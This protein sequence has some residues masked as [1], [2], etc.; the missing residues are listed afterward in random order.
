MAAKED[1][2]IDDSLKVDAV[3]R[4]LEKDYG[5]GIVLSGQDFLENKVQLIPFSP[6]F[7]IILGGGLEEGSF[8]GLTGQPKIGKTTAALDFAATCQLAQYGCR[9][10]FYGKVEGRLSRTHLDG[11]RR[12]NKE[13]GKFNIITS[14]PDK[15]LT[16]QDHL[17]AYKDILTNV[18]GAVLIID[19]ISSLCDERELA[20]GVGTETRGGTAKLFNQFLRLVNQVVPVNRCIVIGI[21]HLISNTSGM[22]APWVERASQGWK[23]MC[24]YQL[25]AVMKKPWV[26]GKD[27]VGFTTTWECKTSKNGPPGLKIDSWFR[28]GEGID[29]LTELIEFGSQGGIVKKAGSWLTIEFGSE[30][31]RAQGKD[32]L[33]DILLTKPTVIEE[34]QKK[35]KELVGLGSASNEG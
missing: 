32:K 31:I 20:D 3:I 28:F 27:V 23:Y 12:L 2:I 33:R 25:K 14:T 8:V 19:S 11:I 6:S 4:Q 17:R 22:G 29:H 13:R 24:D 30:P 9:P 21:T 16:M 5:Q 26:N 34:L 1:V 18:P 35:V 7:D 15:I 10:V